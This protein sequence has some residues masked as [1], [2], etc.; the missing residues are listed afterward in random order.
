MLTG[1]F[2]LAAFAAFMIAFILINRKIYRHKIM[3]RKVEAVK[4]RLELNKKFWYN[5]ALGDI[6]H[7]FPSCWATVTGEPFSKGHLILVQA[8]LNLPVGELD[9]TVPAE[10]LIEIVQL[11]S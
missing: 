8:K 4:A 3:K 9:A 10:S 6:N 7:T 11:N 5:S 2:L 1:L